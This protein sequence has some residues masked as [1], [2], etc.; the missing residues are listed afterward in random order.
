MKIAL[1]FAFLA[2]SVLAQPNSPMYLMSGCQPDKVSRNVIR[3]AAGVIGD[4]RGL[5]VFVLPAR[6]ELDLAIIGPWGADAPITTGDLCLYVIRNDTTGEKAVIA[7]QS[8]TFGGI[9]YPAGWSFFRKF[10][11]GCVYNL[12]WDG[13]P[14][15]H[16]AGWPNPYI[17]FTDAQYGAPWTALAAGASPDWA[18]IDLSPWIPDNA[19]LAEINCE[20]R[21]AGSGGAGSAYIRS[22]NGQSTGLIVGAANPWAGSFSAQRLRVRSDRRFDYRV[23]GGARLYIYILGYFMTEPS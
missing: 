21:Y 15:F 4:T 14:N 23:T 1:L 9:V 7:S 2:S 17:R 18:E 20:V 3:I 19:R 10:P 8:Q 13:V 16:L 6:R 22:Y 12:A 5:E 11:W